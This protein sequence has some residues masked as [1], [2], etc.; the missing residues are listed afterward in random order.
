D[1][2]ITDGMW[3]I[4]LGNN[5]LFGLVS[6]YA[7]LLLPMWLLAKRI[8]PRLWITPA[9]APLC[10]LSALTN[11]YAIDCLGNAMINPI[12]LLA[13]GA[14]T[15]VVGKFDRR[16]IFEQALGWEA[17][18]GVPGLLGVPDAAGGPGLV[19]ES[20]VGTDPREA[21]AHQ[22]AALGRSL[23]ERDRLPEAEEAW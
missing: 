19:G 21:A 16:E 6:L 15:G 20:A 1:I 5:G 4:A 9:V 18:V 12:Y 22:L 14:V 23:A 2:T 8:N 17:V 11:L 10:V 3:V 7:A 13:L